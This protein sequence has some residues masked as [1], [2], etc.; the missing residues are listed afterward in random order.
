MANPA[1]T[2]WMSGPFLR[3]LAT[4]S[5]FGFSLST[6]YLLP[7]HL[8]VTYAVTPGTLGAVMGIFGLTCV[9]VVPWLGRAVNRIGFVRTLCLTQIL[10]AACSFAFAGLHGVGTAMLLLRI[11][12]GLATA[13]Y[14]TAAVA[15]VCDLAPP[16]RLVQ[17]MGL[18]GAASLIMNA[19]APAV[20]ELVGGCWGFPWA[21]ALSGAAALLGVWC[22]S[23]LPE[24]PRHVCT[25][26]PLAPPAR[27]RPVL[28]AL[29]FSGAGFNVVM[30][31]LSPLALPRGV[32]AV[33]GFFAAYTVAALGVRLFG[34]G[35]GDRLGLRQ[36]GVV[37]MLLYGLAIAA[38]AGVQPW[39]LIGLGLLFGFAHGVL[40]PAL[41]AMLFQGTKPSERA[42]LA[43]LSNGVM[44]LGMLTVPVFG[45]IA[46]RV[47]LVPVFLFTGALVS[48]SAWSLTRGRTV[49]ASAT[50]AAR[51]TR[52]RI[53][54]ED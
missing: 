33:S 2:R 50:P 53:L 20:A 27:F 38:M 51:W 19:I 15:M 31:F 39:S 29:A 46:N 13:G 54:P 8:T 16:E 34:G 41:M 43:G 12:Q 14:M 3:L 32:H 4:N 6:F 52:V 26:A 24:Q 30:A 23:K 45:Q 9:L 5:A 7:K 21:F 18:S 25:T 49:R 1:S 17:A 35:I 36:T 22:A 28:V 37:S 40:F 10:I 48:A 42:S 11:L 47:G 44:S